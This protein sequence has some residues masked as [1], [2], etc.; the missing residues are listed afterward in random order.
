M[1]LF[2]VIVSA[3]V[4]ALYSITEDEAAC[5][6]IFLNALWKLIS[7]WRY[8]EQCFERQVDGKPGGA[9]RN[10][11][12]GKNTIRVEQQS[13]SHLDYVK[14]Y[15]EWHASLGVAFVGCLQSTEYMHTRAALIVLSRMND[16]FPTKSTL[17]EK[18]LEALAPLQEDDN[19]MQDIKAMAQ[20]YSSKIIK[21]RDTG[22]WKEEDSKAAKAREDREKQQK[23]NRKKNIEK[24]F[25]EMQKDSEQIDR[26]LGDG[27][28]D[29]KLHDR[30]GPPPTLP[31][32]RFTAPV[33]NSGVGSSTVPTAT[34]SHGD[35]SGRGQDHRGHRDD[36]P[37]HGRGPRRDE[38][39]N[40]G[41][42]GRWE[43]NAAPADGGKGTKRARSPENNRETTERGDRDRDGGEEVKK[44]G[45]SFFS[46]SPGQ[47]VNQL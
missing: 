29:R 7:E 39:R 6:G 24:Q 15:N 28:K 43:R 26:Q 8:D 5:L 41:L 36:R 38:T 37:Q 23:K 21:A 9:W 22:S 13:I 42:Q 27:H 12:S 34:Q 33:S 35:R 4:G 44:R 20:A 1:E 47:A 31:A 45:I 19:P 46:A 40:S 10:N 32:S 11:P 14:L 30:R 25:A 17:G 18:L 2:D 16:H 3:V